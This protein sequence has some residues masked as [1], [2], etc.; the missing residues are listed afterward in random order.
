MSLICFDR[1]ALCS[2]Y[3]EY[4]LDEASIAAQCIVEA[5]YLVMKHA[6]LLVSPPVTG[7]QGHSQAETGHLFAEGNPESIQVA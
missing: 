1:T 2:K 4:T 3:A 5:V 6:W 7:T